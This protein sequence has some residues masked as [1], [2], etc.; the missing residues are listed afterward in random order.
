MNDPF[1][2]F[3]GQYTQPLDAIFRPKS[4]AVIGAKD[5]VGSVGRTIMV[6]LTTGH[7]P[8]ALYPINPKRSEVLGLVYRKL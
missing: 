3:I 4:V 8:G 2:N 7:F 6:N 1:Q 5:T